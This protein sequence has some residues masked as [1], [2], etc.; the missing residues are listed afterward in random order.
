MAAHY[1][2]DDEIISAACVVPSEMI[3]K[4]ER[5]LKQIKKVLKQ[6]LKIC[7]VVW[8]DNTFAFIAFDA[9]LKVPPA[10]SIISAYRKHHNLPVDKTKNGD[11]N[12]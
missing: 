3:F 1:L 8:L 10:K 7:V 6:G 4:S 12:V 9:V 2:T 5:S 11:T